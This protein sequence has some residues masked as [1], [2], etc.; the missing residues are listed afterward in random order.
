MTTPTTASFA[1]SV[2]T[3]VIG[4]AVRR[5]SNMVP[6]SLLLADDI[7]SAHD[8]R[9]QIQGRG[10]ALSRF[11]GGDGVTNVDIPQMAEVIVRRD[12]RQSVARVALNGESGDLSV[13]PDEGVCSGDWGTFTRDVSEDGHWPP[14]LIRG[15]IEIRSWA[16]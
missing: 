5:P 7:K 10:R 16:V 12:K 6:P 15:F 13:V 2:G 1:N 11:F 3:P 14:L 9:L 4:H 8:P